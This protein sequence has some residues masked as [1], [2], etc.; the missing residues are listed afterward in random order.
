MRVIVQEFGREENEKEIEE[1][2]NGV[3][4]KLENRKFKIID[5]DVKP[6]D[7]QRVYFL[8]KYE[9]SYAGR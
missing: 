1:S 9:P 4:E 8:I 5:I 3:I 7:A 6:T 2:I